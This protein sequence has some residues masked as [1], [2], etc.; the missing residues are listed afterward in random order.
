MHH[1][2]TTRLRALSKNEISHYW[3][4]FFKDPRPYKAVHSEMRTL[5]ASEN[6]ECFQK[7]KMRIQRCAEV[8]GSYFEGMSGL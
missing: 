3:E 6:G 5:P 7:W 2:H 8:E 4:A 1:T